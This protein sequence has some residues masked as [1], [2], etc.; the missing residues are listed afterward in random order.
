MHPSQDRVEVRE[1]GDADPS[2]NLVGDDSAKP[3]RPIAS[4]KAWLVEEVGR[5]LPIDLGEGTQLDHIQSA[6]AGL[7]FRDE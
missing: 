4:Y 2:G 6:F 3:E 5:G 1:Q 7:G